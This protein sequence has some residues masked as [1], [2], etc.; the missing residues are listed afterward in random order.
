VFLCRSNAWPDHI[1][2]T[3]HLGVSSQQVVLQQ[4]VLHAPVSTDVYEGANVNALETCWHVCVSEFKQQKETDPAEESSAAHR[5][6]GY[7][8]ADQG[9]I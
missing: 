8:V 2:E 7:A 3:F 9:D 1:L 5:R 4:V 6:W